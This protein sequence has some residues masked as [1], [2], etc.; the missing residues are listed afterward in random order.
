MGIWGQNDVVS[1]SMRRHYVASTL[2]RRHFTSC[3]RWVC[4]GGAQD[5]EAELRHCMPNVSLYFCIRGKF[6]IAVFE[7]SGVD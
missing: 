7:I 4:S 1:T 3:A 2:I 6:E 5:K